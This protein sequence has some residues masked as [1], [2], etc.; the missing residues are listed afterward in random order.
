MEAC[1]A[2]QLCERDILKLPLCPQ[3]NS[4]TSPT[5]SDQIRSI[6]GDQNHSI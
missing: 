6:G 3:G 5:N 4:G 1:A 2:T